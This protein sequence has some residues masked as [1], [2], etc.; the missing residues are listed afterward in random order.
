MQMWGR[1]MCHK[2]AV[3]VN[4]RKSVCEDRGCVNVKK[5]VFEEG[6]VLTSK[7]A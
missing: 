7:R 3:C 5:S 1:S 4:L 2:K 6:G